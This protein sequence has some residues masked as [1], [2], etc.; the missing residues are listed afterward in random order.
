MIPVDEELSNHDFINAIQTIKLG[1][2]R[3]NE[4]SVSRLQERLEGNQLNMK[5]AMI[6]ICIIHAVI[7]KEIFN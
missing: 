5:Y 6:I 1:R 7:P 3:R 4:K 2:P